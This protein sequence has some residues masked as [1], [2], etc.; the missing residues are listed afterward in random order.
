M[1]ERAAQ[2]RAAG[3]GGLLI[4]DVFIEVEGNVFIYRKKRT[5]SRE[6]C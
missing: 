2:E 6:I 1:G 5:V 3:S 4:K